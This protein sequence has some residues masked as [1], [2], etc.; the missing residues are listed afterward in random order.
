MS[1]FTQ[2]MKAHR[3]NLLDRQALTTEG[4]DG[5]MPASY[6]SLLSRLKWATN[7]LNAPMAATV[8]I[9]SSLNKCVPQL[10]AGSTPTL[11][12]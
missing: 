2:L 5:R 7:R 4:T 1:S 3:F 6:S 10:F 8:M 11:P 12:R 9:R